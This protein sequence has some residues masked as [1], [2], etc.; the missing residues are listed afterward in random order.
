MYT[1]PATGMPA[2]HVITF[3]N[4]HINAYYDEKYAGYEQIGYVDFS[5]NCH[6][7]AFGT[8]NWPESSHQG[9]GVLLANTCYLY[10]MPSD[11]E[12]AWSYTHSIKVSGEECDMGSGMM[13]PHIVLTTEKFRASR[14]YKQ[15]GSCG[16]PANPYRAHV[17]PSFSLELRRRVPSET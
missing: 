11:A 10:A 13:M 7:Y 12:V 4:D 6:G 16:S 1:D 2:S 9:I 17:D 5:I 14:V 15:T 3:N 8:G